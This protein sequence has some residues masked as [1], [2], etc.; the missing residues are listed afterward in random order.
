MTNIY[1]VVILTYINL[2]R[3]GDDM[4]IYVAMS[5]NTKQHFHRYMDSIL[6]RMIFQTSI[7]LIWKERNSRRHQ[8]VWLST[9]T[10]IRR[11]DKSIRNRIS[12]LK[13]TGSHKSAGLLRRWLEAFTRQQFF[14]FN[15]KEI[16]CFDDTIVLQ[17]LQFFL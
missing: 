13:Y 1:V 5:V 17:L 4:Y 14:Y 6:L 12:S 7:Y 11:I 15:R 3:L 2:I 8:G 9:D 10:M 16:R